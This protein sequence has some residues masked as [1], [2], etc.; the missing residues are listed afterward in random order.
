MAERRVSLDRPAL[1]VIADRLAWPGAIAV[2]GREARS[3]AGELARALTQLG[4][5]A[6]L[7]RVELRNAEGA[8]VTGEREVTVHAHPDALRD[9]LA[10]LPRGPITIG[11]GAAFA[12]AVRADL[13]VWIRGGESATLGPVERELTREAK[14]VLD[15]PRPGV[16]A[17]LAERF[18]SRMR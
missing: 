7:V 5:D 10:G 2:F 14:L 11:V 9:A 17:Q 15:A 6:R 8:S 3:F 12:A 16:A 18:A 13:T 4:A 1:P